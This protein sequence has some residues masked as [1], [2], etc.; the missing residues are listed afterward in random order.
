M[1]RKITDDEI[2]RE[3]KK[4]LDRLEIATDIIKSWVTYMNSHLSPSEEI[5][6]ERSKEFLGEKK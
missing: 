2:G 3:I 4:A 1:S 6:V 5:L